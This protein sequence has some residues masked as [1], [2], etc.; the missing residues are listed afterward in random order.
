M[1]F[2]EISNL[3]RP[4]DFSYF[5]N[6]LIAVLSLVVF[7]LWTIL[8]IVSG[9]SIFSSV[10]FGVQVGLVLFLSWAI[11]R[12]VDP[13]HPFSA[14]LAGF[15]GLIV[16]ISWGEINLS[17]MFWVVLAL[18]ILNQCVGLPLTLF[19][20]VSFLVFSIYLSLVSSFLFGIFFLLVF[21]LE[22]RMPKASGKSRK[23]WIFGLFAGILGFLSEPRFDFLW[24]PINI[25]AVLLFLSFFFFSLIIKPNKGIVS[26][27]DKTGKPLKLVRIKTAQVFF[28][29]FV[30]VLSFSN[31]FLVM[32]PYW[33]IILGIISYRAY[34]LVRSII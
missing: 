18:R 33:G 31:N 32:I 1:K 13:D 28:I 30:I 29:T 27:G 25:S 2:D 14:F 34:V 12:E 24:L 21:L 19:D 3:G 7:G 22:S 9:S 5:T 16:L 23:L 6:R 11:A 8:E 17:Y 26:V 4:I 15:L 10:S 20:A